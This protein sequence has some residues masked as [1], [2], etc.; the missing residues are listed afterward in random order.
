MGLTML[1]SRKAANGSNTWAKKLC[2]NQG[3]FTKFNIGTKSEEM[4]S[5]LE[6]KLGF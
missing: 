6:I 2:V 1:C 4:S 3:L 5:S